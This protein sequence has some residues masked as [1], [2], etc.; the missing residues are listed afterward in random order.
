[1]IHLAVLDMAGTTVADD[2]AVLHAFTEAMVDLGAEPDSDR[3]GAALDHVQAT[4]GSSKIEVFRAL[5][6]TEEEAVEANRRFEAAYADAVAAEG[7]APVPGAEEAM[8]ALRE[9]GVKVCLTTGFSAVTRDLLIDALGW[10][11][12][13]DLVLSPSAEARGRPYPDMVLVA[14]LRLG[15]DDVR[16]VA[17]AGDTASDLLSGSRAGAGIVAGVLTGAHGRAE[18]DAAPHTHI[19]DRVA[20]LPAVV[21]GT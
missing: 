15:I 10:A 18:L 11:D 3:M 2:G 21:S 13:V 16:E 7:A 19:L 12:R 4:M 17:V 20:D 1:M 6:D 14:V 5:S 9:S 8:A